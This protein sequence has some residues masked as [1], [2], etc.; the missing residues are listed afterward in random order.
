MCSLFHSVV[1]K[2]LNLS[3][4]QTGRHI[5]FAWCPCRKLWYGGLKKKCPSWAQGLEY[6]VP[7][8]GHCVRMLWNLQEVETC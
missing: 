1:F 8:W 2:L 6:L 4:G 3:I 7:I 5:E